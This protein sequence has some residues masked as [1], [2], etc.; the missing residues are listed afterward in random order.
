[1]APADFLLEAYWTCKDF[2]TGSKMKG[3]EGATRILGFDL[4][5]LSPRD[6]STG[7][8][9]GRVQ[10][11][12]FR[13]QKP[14]DLSSPLELDALLNNK[15]I[16]ECKIAYYGNKVDGSGKIKQFEITLTDFHV[17]HLIQTGTGGAAGVTETVELTY[18]KIVVID[19]PST[20]Q[21]EYEWTGALA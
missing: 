14:I 9:T 4:E 18:S 15:Q 12:P 19:V 5:F 6:M 2:S 3:M 13:I 20:K 7:Q 21:T 10:M 17:V 16:K 1:M 8:A 11:K